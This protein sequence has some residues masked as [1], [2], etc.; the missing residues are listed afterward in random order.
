MPR[1]LPV[2]AGDHGP[3][4]AL[5]GR[6]NARAIA[7]PAGWQGGV[8]LQTAQG[9]SGAGGPGLGGTSAS[10]GNRRGTRALSEA[11]RAAADWPLSR[12]WISLDFHWHP[13]R[14]WCWCGWAPGDPGPAHRGAVRA[15]RVRRWS[16]IRLGRQGGDGMARRSRALVTRSRG[17]L[18][19]CFPMVGRRCAASSWPVA[20]GRPIGW[21]AEVAPAGGV[22]LLC[23]GCVAV[24]SASYCLLALGG[25]SPQ[26][27]AAADPGHSSALAAAAAAAHFGWPLQQQ[28]VLVRTTPESSPRP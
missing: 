14:A 13:Q 12:H 1:C 2:S 24:C 10:L 16:P 25:A 20:S 17:P 22:V 19:L 11:L 18:P 3:V 4:V 7:I 6:G 23:G 8:D 15:I 27:S 28:G 21:R 5:R 26:L 9:V